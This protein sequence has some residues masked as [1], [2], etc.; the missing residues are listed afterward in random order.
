MS[1]ILILCGSLALAQDDSAVQTGAPTPPEDRD[2]DVRSDPRIVETI[3]LT[4]EVDDLA[5]HT[6][7]LRAAIESAGGTILRHH[8]DN[9]S[10]WGNTIFIQALVP[11]QNWPAVESSISLG[12]DDALERDAV[13][14]SEQEGE[15]PP[16]V[17]VSIHLELPTEREPNF[18]V[19]ASGSVLFPADDT[20]PGLA[21]LVTMRVM[22]PDRDGA[23]EVAYAPA[24]ALFSEQDEPWMLQITGG[25][26]MYSEYLGGGER[27]V[28]NPFIGGKMG[29]AYRG[30]SWFVLQGELGLELLHI[31]HVI[32]DVYARPTGYFRSGSVGLAV[33][34]GMG[35]VF[36]F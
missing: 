29:Y 6:D 22:N 23:L 30:Q 27:T 26:A 25:G 35:L 1:A 11:V 34:T 31:N 9:D 12:P 3:D 32:L 8:N 20:G 24:S 14:R 21:Q 2:S 16:Q 33:E 28:L 5:R 13:P 10:D 17:D 36:P 15:G 18:L 19:G 4:V 7:K